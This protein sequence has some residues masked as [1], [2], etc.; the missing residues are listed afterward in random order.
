MERTMGWPALNLAAIAAVAVLSIACGADARAPGGPSAAPA[1]GLAPSAPPLAAAAASQAATS[2]VPP[3]ATAGRASG[4]ASLSPIRD[5]RVGVLQNNGESGL[6][7]AIEHGYFR[8]EGIN[9]EVV[10]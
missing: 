7:L 2:G 9:V 10:P 3:E 8:Q 1:A 4:P 5:V 6:Y